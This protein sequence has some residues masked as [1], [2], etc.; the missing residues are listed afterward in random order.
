MKAMKGFIG[1]IIFLVILSLMT[2]TAVWGLTDLFAFYTENQFTGRVR[3]FDIK[4][5]D[6]VYGSGFAFLSTWT[7]KTFISSVRQVVEAG[8]QQELE[9]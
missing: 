2:G 4:Y 5:W 7:I 8:Q 6:A 9:E 3:A 1:G